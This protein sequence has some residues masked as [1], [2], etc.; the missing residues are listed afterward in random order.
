M[1]D[2]LLPG[3]IRDARP[4]FSAFDVFL[5]TSVYEG[6]SV[7]I[8][9]AIQAGCPVVAADV[10]GNAEALDAESELVNDHWDTEA[11]VAGIE[12]V[13][14]GRRPSTL[15][16]A[17]DH[18]LVPRLWCLLAR[19]ATVANIMK[20]WAWLLTAILGVSQAPRADT[21]RV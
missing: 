14:R 11:Y 16:P 20:I 21:L 4:Y 9:E 15:S 7:A 6:L 18:D 8:L 12:K 3:A 17:S 2:L 1:P 5:N 19:H 10:G 13:V